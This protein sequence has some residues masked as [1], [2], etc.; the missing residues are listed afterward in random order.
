VKVSDSE[1]RATIN[2]GDVLGV[3]TIGIY[4]EQIPPTPYTNLLEFEVI[5]P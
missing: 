3:G 4:N 2:V 1:A 5:P